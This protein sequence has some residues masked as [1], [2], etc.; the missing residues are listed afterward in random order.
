MQHI[1]GDGCGTD[2]SP[3]RETAGQGEKCKLQSALADVDAFA[4]AWN[5]GGR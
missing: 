3:V 1:T 4:W 2:G 5:Y